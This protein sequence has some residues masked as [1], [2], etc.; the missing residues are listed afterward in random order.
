MQAVCVRFFVEEG[1][2]HA[3]R[4]LHEWLFETAQAL[5]ISGGTAFRACAGFG[6]HGLHVDHFFELAGQL[7]ETLEFIADA[8]RIDALIRQ[9]GASGLRLVYAVHLVELG[10]TGD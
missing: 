2:K 5:G 1:M 10:V 9:V 6:R 8:D 3:H 4:P 7:P